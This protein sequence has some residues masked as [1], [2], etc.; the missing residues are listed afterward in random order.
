MPMD[1]FLRACGASA[2]L[3]LTV[4]HRGLPAMLWSRPQPFALIGRDPDADLSLD[5]PR[6]DRYHTYLQMIEGGVYWVD[7]ESQTGTRSENGTARTGWLNRSQGIAIGPYLIGLAPEARPA[8]GSIARRTVLPDPFSS[9][10]PES[11]DLPRAILEFRRDSAKPI[12]WRMRHI[13]TLL[14]NSPHCKVRLAAAGVSRFHCSLLRTPLGL[15]VVNLLG[16]EGLTVNGS[17]I[18]AARL[19]DGD[20]LRLGEIMIRVLFPASGMVPGEIRA[21][22]GTETY[23]ASLL[24]PSAVI[25]RELATSQ[26]KAPLVV[27]PGSEAAR[28]LV[29]RVSREGELSSSL[30]ATVIDEFGEM[31]QQFLSQFQQTTMMM[32]RAL[33][34]MHRDQMDEL[35]G[36]LDSLQ[37]ITDNLQAFQAHMATT[38]APANGRTA[39]EG[40][41][42]IPPAPEAAGPSDRVAG[43]AEK[44]L[45]SVAAMLRETQAAAENATK[46]LRGR[47]RSIVDQPDMPSPNVHEWLIGRLASLEDEQRSRWQ[48]ILD[49]V[50]GR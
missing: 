39:L 31:Q 3:Q 45:F 21:L 16:S 2:P 30:L 48:K 40:G 14:G 26:A 6:V 29:E 28:L 47:A 36:K 46:E 9:R 38:V 12:R 50:R 13:L 5:S 18:R 10:P 49:L 24:P 34:T 1:E 23:R 35:R 19:E 22:T 42:P 41:P 20:E 25:S 11:D 27:V 33:G 32:F 43:D 37:Q 15:W 7:L 4:E 44:D 17:E 8:P